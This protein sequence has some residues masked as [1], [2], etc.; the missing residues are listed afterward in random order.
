[1]VAT[2]SCVT[3]ACRALSPSSFMSHSRQPAAFSKK[4]ALVKG[5]SGLGWASALVSLHPSLAVGVGQVPVPRSL[6]FLIN[7]MGMVITP[8]L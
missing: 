3:S 4:P 5:K 7:E 6:R 2:P 8:P 1:M